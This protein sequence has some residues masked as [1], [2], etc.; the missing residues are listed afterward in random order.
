M[1]EAKKPS[2]VSC[3]SSVFS[4]KSIVLYKL[5]QALLAT[6]VEKKSSLSRMSIESSSGS[7]EGSGDLR[8]T[9][10]LLNEAF[11]AKATRQ[12]P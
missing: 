9:P 1:I 7:E 6:F 8:M 11:S 10:E 5:T 2:R 4:D 3:Y 12:K